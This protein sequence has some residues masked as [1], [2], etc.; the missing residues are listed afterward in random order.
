MAPAN[1]P[2]LDSLIEDSVGIRTQMQNMQKQY[3]ENRGR[4]FELLTAADMKSYKYSNYKV[5]RTEAISI[6]SVSKELLIKALQDVDIP[7]EKKVFIWNN[8]IKEIQRP[9]MVTIQ[10]QRKQPSS[11]PF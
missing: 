7:R 10:T 1:N 3:D 6:E 5:F 2:E 8:S 9:A 11:E 4:I